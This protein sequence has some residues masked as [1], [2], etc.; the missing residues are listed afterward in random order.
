MSLRIRISGRMMTLAQIEAA[1]DAASMLVKA[2]NDAAPSDGSPEWDSI[3]WESID[4][5]HARAVEAFQES[6]GEQFVRL[7]K[8]EHAVD[9]EGGLTD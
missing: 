2:Y 1:V 8:E 3:E 7:S 6:P 4:S 5:A 9:S